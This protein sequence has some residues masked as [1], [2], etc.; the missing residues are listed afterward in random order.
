MEFG[1]HQPCH[2][3]RVAFHKCSR[4]RF[5][6]RFKDRD[7]EC[8][9]AGFTRPAGQDQFTR[10]DRVFESCEVPRQ[11]HFIFFRPVRVQMQ[12]RHEP[13][14]I[15]EL[16]GFFSLQRL[17]RQRLTKCE[18]ES[19]QND[20]SEMRH[21]GVFHFEQDFRIKPELELNKMHRIRLI[22]SLLVPDGEGF[23]SLELTDLFIELMLKI[24][25]PTFGKRIDSDGSA[26]PFQIVFL[27]SIKTSDIGHADILLLLA[28]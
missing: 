11:R 26:Q 15:D 3:S 25:L 16:L 13:Q 6:F 8:L 1:S 2:N 12:P 7:P 28:D 9:I 21:N 10:F 22:P 24:T 4:G 20:E 17:R 5:I 18:S 27:K 14:H 19:Q 23:F